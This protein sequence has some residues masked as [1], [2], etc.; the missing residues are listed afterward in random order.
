MYERE[1][2]TDIYLCRVN[3][4]EDNNHILDFVDINSQNTFFDNLPGKFHL[5]DA[6]FQRKN[7]Y[8]RMDGKFDQI[9]LYNYGWYDN[10]L[11]NMRYYFL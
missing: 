9:Q 11:E 7:M 10:H 5:E 1:P 4:S 8:I 2:V 3:F 6:T